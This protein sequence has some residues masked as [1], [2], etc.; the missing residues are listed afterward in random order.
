MGTRLVFLDA[1]PACLAWR[2]DDCCYL[3]LGCQALGAVWLVDRGCLMSMPS[4]KDTARSNAISLTSSTVQS[5]GGIPTSTRCDVK[6]PPGPPTR[7]FAWHSP[8]LIY[9][10]LMQHDSSTQL[11]AHTCQIFREPHDL[12]DSYPVALHRLAVARYSI[13]WVGIR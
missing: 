13:N 9:E 1:M 4:C 7:R 8:H 2:S 3:A 11:Y 5:A 10:A 6:K 12:V